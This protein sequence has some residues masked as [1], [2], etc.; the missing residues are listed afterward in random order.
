MLVDKYEAAFC[1]L[2]SILR[3]GYLKP[4]F[5]PRWRWTVRG[6]E[7]KTI[8]GPH[9]AVCFTDQP[10]SAF[11]QSC[12][13]LSSRYSPYGIALEKRNLFIYGGRP[14][15]YGDTNLLALL[16]DED[17]YLW[18]RYNPVPD[19]QF[20]EYPVDWT[21]EREWRA[22]VRKHGFLD[23]GFTSDEGVPLV[24]PPDYNGR[25]ISVSLPRVLVRTME[26]VVEL[27][28]WL[29]SLPKYEDTNGFVR[30]YYDNLLRLSIIPLDFVY[31]RL[32]AGDTRWAR[33]ETLPYGEIPAGD[34]GHSTS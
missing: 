1:V 4:S 7:T 9:P 26:E 31:E 19:S 11:I 2:Q 22:R 6:Q 23:W 15:I 14:V 21:H 13:T 18:V 34:S 28:K 8:Q 33:L 16:N 12:R 30:K 20:G 29:V 10:L 24:L 5:G 27:H 17:K 25:G 3:C 32:E